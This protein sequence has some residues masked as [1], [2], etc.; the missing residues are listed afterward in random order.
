MKSSYFSTTVFFL[1]IILLI[2]SDYIYPTLD[3][4]ITQKL[5]EIVSIGMI[6]SGI[7]IIFKNFIEQKRN[8]KRNGTDKH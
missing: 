4:S 7:I 1:G 3:Y 6:I 8:N 2:L 5:L